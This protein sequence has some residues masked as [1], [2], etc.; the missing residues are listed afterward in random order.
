MTVLA[1][2][3]F[4]RANN[5]DLGTDWTA[6]SGTGATLKVLTNEAANSTSATFCLEYW[7]GALVGGGAWPND[8]YAQITVGTVV[9]TSTDNGAG[10]AIR[11]STSADTFY[12]S[13]TNTHE[14]RVYKAV[15]GAFTQMG[16][17]GAACAAGNTLRLTMTGTSISALKN[18][19]T[20]IG[21]VTDAGIAS[22]KAALWISG[23]A[24]ATAND[25]EG[26]DISSAD[27]L[28][29]QACL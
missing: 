2:D 22:G 7:S 20:F 15:A 17:D 27:T 5:A 6:P 8:Q 14:T 11:I 19:V 18:G 28:M 1:S 29:G 9:E 4:T 25:W 12:I 10:P 13:Q 23:T 21:P 24:T 16:S 26:G 3:A